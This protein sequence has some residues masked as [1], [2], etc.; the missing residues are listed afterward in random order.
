MT[1]NHRL[2]RCTRYLLASV[3]K[4]CLV[5][6]GIYLLAAFGLPLLLQLTASG[7]ITYTIFGPD[8]M[9]S[10]VV[11]LFAGAIFLFVG[12]YAG[13][14]EDYNFLLAMSNTWRNQYGAALLRTAVVAAGFTAVSFLMG[15]F[16]RLFN[17]MVNQMANLSRITDPG[18]VSTFVYTLGGRQPYSLAGEIL[19]VFAAFL[20][21]FLFGQT[22]AVYS[23]RWGVRFTVTFW[24]L[25]G[26]SYIF[27]PILASISEGFR[28][29]VMWF[30][31]EGEGDTLLN[32]GW[33]LL[34]IAAMLIGLTGLGMRR[35]SQNA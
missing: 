13:F 31:S 4:P 21:V 27:L 25:F 9:V 30:L 23:Y 2:L 34:V 35:L 33:H 10:S 19:L 32:I 16:E 22:A 15:W 20:T 5:F 6:L 17:Q 7:G 26:T 3:I 18:V 29:F 11:F 8:N 24:I 14:R 1:A 12:G 28:R